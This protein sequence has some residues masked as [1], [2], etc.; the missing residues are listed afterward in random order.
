MTDFALWWYK[1]L[2][3]ISNNN[4]QNSLESMNHWKWFFK[5]YCREFRSQFP[6]LNNNLV[7]SS[8]FK[9][10]C[11]KYSCFLFPAIENM[12]RRRNMA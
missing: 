2:Q 8:A 9:E 6:G 4:I 1:T 10:W 11:L 12:D 3:L 5:K 7:S